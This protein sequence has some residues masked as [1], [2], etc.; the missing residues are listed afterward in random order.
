[1]SRDDDQHGRPLLTANWL[2]WA[3]GLY[4]LVT[5][6][7]PLLSVESFQRVTGPKSDHLV[8]DPPT[9]ADHWM[10]N[11]ISGLIVAIALVLLAAAWRQKPSFEVG[12]LGVLSAAALVAIDLVYVG[13]GTIRPIYLA[14]AAV[15]V[16]IMA[17]WGWVAWRA[18]AARRDM[19]TGQER[20]GVK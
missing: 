5:A 7:W 15:E 20:G 8:A 16:G 3:Q 19:A 10:L 12:L 6:V 1:L 11:T 13:R 17:A 4:Y 9:E 14:D 2:C 18:S